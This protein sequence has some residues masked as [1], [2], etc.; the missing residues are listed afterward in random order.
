MAFSPENLKIWVNPREYSRIIE[1]DTYPPFTKGAS[2]PY[3]SSPTPRDV[4]PP[5]TRKTA[6][7]HHRQPRAARPVPPTPSIPHTPSGNSP[8]PRDMSTPP[9]SDPPTPTAYSPMTLAQPP[10]P[11]LPAHEYLFPQRT[12]TRTPSLTA[13]R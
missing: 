10:H 13:A 11:P 9:P 8:T 6:H 1:T 4:P 2:L 5:P 12:L 3:T 7:A